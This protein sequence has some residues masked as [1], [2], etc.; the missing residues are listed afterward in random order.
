MKN[1][2]KNRF[3]T[4]FQWSQPFDFSL[5]LS[6]FA[7]HFCS[8]Y[9]QFLTSYRFC[10]QYVKCEATVVGSSVWKKQ[11]E[12]IGFI[13]IIPT[14][15]GRA[16]WW[17]GVKY[18]FLLKIF[19]KHIIW[20]IKPPIISISKVIFVSFKYWILKQKYISNIARDRY[21]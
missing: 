15:V 21:V 18:W 4:F 9:W 17:E 7:L 10:S 12:F 20:W 19:S 13:S 14:S 11:E 8:F 2:H 16:I 6:C 5:H 1:C 3:S